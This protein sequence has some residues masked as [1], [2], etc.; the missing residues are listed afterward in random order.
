MASEFNKQLLNS[1]LTVSEIFLLS[2]RGFTP[3][4]AFPG[5]IIFDLLRNDKRGREVKKSTRKITTID[6]Y[7]FFYQTIPTI[8]PDTFTPINRKKGAG[9]EFQQDGTINSHLRRQLI[10]PACV[11][12]S[13]NRQKMKEWK[14]DDRT[15]IEAREARWGCNWSRR[16]IA[17]FV[18]RVADAMYVRYE[19]DGG[20]SLI[21]VDAG[22]V[23]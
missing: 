11:K 12:L 9:G 16:K 7:F 4:N 22:L 15:F 20:L 21:A 23:N 1:C 17:Y 19:R 13:A 6:Y 18:P 8:L 10:A 5:T 3:N 14:T 2:I